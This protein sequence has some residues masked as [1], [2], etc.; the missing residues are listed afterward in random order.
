MTHKF[1]LWLLLE[2]VRWTGLTGMPSLAIHEAGH[3]TRAGALCWILCLPFFFFFLFLSFCR[4]KVAAANWWVQRKFCR[5]TFRAAS[6]MR[7]RRQDTRQR[8]RLALS[9]KDNAQETQDEHFLI[10]KPSRWNRRL[11]GKLAS[12]QRV[13]PLLIA[14]A[15]E[16]EREREKRMPFKSRQWLGIFSLS[17]NCSEYALIIYVLNFCKRATFLLNCCMKHSPQQPTAEAITMPKLMWAHLFA[18]LN[19]YKTINC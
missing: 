3:L 12:N 9:F 15:Q 1:V 19:Y 5:R 16:R 18:R 14:P 2:S 13:Q 8:Q 17:W 6:C 10:T 4:W 11:H 7:H